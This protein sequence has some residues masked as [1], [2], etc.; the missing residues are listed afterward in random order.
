MAEEGKPKVGAIVWHDLTVRDAGPVR[1]FYAAVVGWRHDPVEMGGYSDFNMLPPE[2][3]VPTAG[4]CHARGVNAKLPPQW[5]VYVQVVDLDASLK[6]TGEETRY[7]PGHG[8]LGSRA[9]LVAYRDVVTAARDRIAK[10][11][12]AG[13]TKHEVIAAKP[14]AEWDAKWG[15]GFM[16]P[17]LWTGI[18]FDSLD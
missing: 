8:P 10:L 2:G 4:I 18:V 9:D 13:K 6:G 5:V 15:G 12:A 7:I 14:T 11:K 16:K 1:D 17:D 3:D